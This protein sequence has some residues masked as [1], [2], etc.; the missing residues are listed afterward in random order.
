MINSPID[1]HTH[2]SAQVCV[3]WMCLC[4]MAE[5]WELLLLVYSSDPLVLHVHT[6]LKHDLCICLMQ[7]IFYLLYVLGSVGHVIYNSGTNRHHSDSLQCVTGIQMCVW[8]DVLWVR[9]DVLLYAVPL[10]TAGNSRLTITTMACFAGRLEII[11]LMSPF[12][13]EFPVTH[14]HMLWAPR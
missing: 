4:C 10:R 14:T 3:C 8:S 13:L 11:R 5:H 12:T 2:S 9:S 7:F 1:T 6:R